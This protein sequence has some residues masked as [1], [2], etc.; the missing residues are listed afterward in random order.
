MLLSLSSA[1][2]RYI[3]VYQ[4]QWL[5][6]SIPLLSAYATPLE[7]ICNLYG[8]SGYAV[9]NMK[10][11]KYRIIIFTHTCHM[12]ML[13]WIVSKRSKNWRLEKLSKDLKLQTIELLN[14]TKFLIV[15]ILDKRF[16]FKN[17]KYILCYEALCILTCV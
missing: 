8:T 6:K 5:M 2:I 16:V 13:F 9:L 7:W 3:S 17:K 1:N 11:F 4:R 10:T 15:S 12:H 14:L